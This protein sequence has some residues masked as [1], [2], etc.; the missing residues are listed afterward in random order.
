MQFQTVLLI[1]L[2]S[3]RQNTNRAAQQHPTSWHKHLM[4]CNFAQ[5]STEGYRVMTQGLQM[6]SPKDQTHPQTQLSCARHHFVARIVF[7][8]CGCLKLLQH[9]KKGYQA[10]EQMHAQAN[11]QQ[12]LKFTFTPDVHDACDTLACSEALT[13]HNRAACIAVLTLTHRHAFRQVLV[14]CRDCSY[15]GLRAVPVAARLIA[16]ATQQVT[17]P[18][19]LTPVLM[20]SGPQAFAD[21]SVSLSS[22]LSSTECPDL[23]ILWAQMMTLC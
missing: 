18:G 5:D 23:L 10:S 9:R 6:H 20:Q 14:T 17:E 21:H 2:H 11:P 12:P 7:C 13:S 4:R 22:L 19:Q 16:W 1:E 8:Y 15:A 3:G